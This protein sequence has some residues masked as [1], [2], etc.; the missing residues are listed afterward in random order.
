[1]HLFYLRR[2]LKSLRKFPRMKLYRELELLMKMENKNDGNLV[3]FT[4]ISSVRTQIHFPKKKKK[5]II[6]NVPFSFKKRQNQK[7]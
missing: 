3:F 1:M 2:L 4:I 6:Q 7:E 5:K